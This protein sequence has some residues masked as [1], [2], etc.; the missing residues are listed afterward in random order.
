MAKTSDLLNLGYDEFSE[1]DER[2]LR[3]VVKQIAD[4]A[5]KRIQRIEKAGYKIRRSTFTAKGKNLNQLRREYVRLKDFFGSSTS[6]ISEIKYTE[7]KTREALKQRGIN[8]STKDYKTFWRAYEKLKELD[9]SIEN[10]KM[11]YKI[12]DD[13][14]QELKQGNNIDDI[15]SNIYDRIE[16]IYESANEAENDFDMNDFFDDDE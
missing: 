2:Q 6:S 14:A 4:T 1:L 8:I 5:N 16:D 10:E 9:P 15:V 12:L 13:I 3:K 11:K 7:K